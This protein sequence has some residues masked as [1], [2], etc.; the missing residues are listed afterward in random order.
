V[1]AEATK[2]RLDVGDVPTLLL[3][4][5]EG[6]RSLPLVLFGHG[7]GPGKD[8]PW[9]Q[10]VGSRYA[11][12]MP[13]AVLMIDAPGHGE[14]APQVG[15]PLENFRAQRQVLRDPEVFG[16]IVG[17]WRAAIAVAAE[18]PDIDATRI[19]YAG[20]SQGT[21]FGIS[22]VAEL[23]EIRAAVFGIGGL[24][25]RGGVAALVRSLGLD[26]ETANV[27]EEEDDPDF[28][29]KTALEAAS[30][31]IDVEVFALQMTDDIVFPLEGSL[32]LFAAYPGPKR[33]G[34]WEGGH[35]ELPDEAIDLSIDFLRRT[36]A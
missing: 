34:L 30:K 16:Q 15:T 4:P 29:A 36:L 18:R 7:G 10:R 12:G 5:P 22:V 20:F 24:P 26:E 1:T 6:G 8:A 25:R 27:I 13:A 28:R 17:D 19:V 9:M 3:T 21:M 31:L 14:R 33:M 23:R 35:T 11:L 2:T 32:E